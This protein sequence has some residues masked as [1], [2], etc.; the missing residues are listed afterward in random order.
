MKFPKHRANCFLVERR[1]LDKVV[2]YAVVG[3]FPTPEGAD[4]YA[5]AC[6]QSFKD[7]GFSDDDY[8]FSVKMSTYYDA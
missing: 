4:E 6:A 3:V 5:E 7:R 8:V 2:S 1:I